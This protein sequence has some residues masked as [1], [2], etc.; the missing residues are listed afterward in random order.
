M[1]CAAALFCVLQLSAQK[2]SLHAE[3]QPLLAQSQA[4]S[5]SGGSSKAASKR[6]DGKDGGKAA[7]QPVLYTLQRFGRLLWNQLAPGGAGL[8][9]MVA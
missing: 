1:L 7:R 5:S 3:M 9:I 8:L 2:S 6:A 4:L